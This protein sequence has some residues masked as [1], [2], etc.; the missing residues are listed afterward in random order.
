MPRNLTEAEARELLRLQSINDDDSDGGDEAEFDDSD[1]DD[2]YTPENDDDDEDDDVEEDDDED[3]EQEANGEPIDPIDETINRV[4]ERALQELDADQDQVMNAAPAAVVDET[5]DRTSKAGVIWNKLDA[6]SETRVR[7]RIYYTR[8]N[9]GPT[10]Y[11]KRRVNESALSTF[12]LIFC[13]SIIRYFLVYDI[14]NNLK[15]ITNI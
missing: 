14:S 13:S 5:I 2:D 9:E 7:N 10:A 8:T 15:I 1:I 3:P 12:N 6:G 4:I 11:A